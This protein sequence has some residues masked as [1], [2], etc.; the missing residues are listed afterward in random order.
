MVTKTQNMNRYSMVAL[1][2]LGFLIVTPVA[3]ASSNNFLQRAT[4]SYQRSCTKRNVSLQNAISCYAFDRL[5]EVD[6][7]LVALK[8]SL[9]LV[10]EDNETQTARI[11]EL[12]QRIAKL[13][14]ATSPTSTTYIVS[15]NSWKFSTTASDGWLDT[16]FDTSSWLTTQAPSGGQCDPSAIGLLINDHGALP[17]SVNNPNWAGGSGY[18]RKTFNL[19]SI[20]S[21]ANV[22]VVLDDDG[23]LYMNNNLVLSDQDNHVAGI[24][25]VDI[26]T[27]YFINGTNV[28]GLKV[29][30]SAGGCQHAQV[31]VKLNL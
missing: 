21:S 18:F 31:E 22:R 1:L 7:L 30:D 5:A 16:D 9:D 24:Q 26:P 28:I 17:M 6:K 19:D 20:P 12:E 4:E 25:Q 10:K 3:I 11:A 2:F 8:S 14:N 23:V 15:N 27:S 13:E 29:V